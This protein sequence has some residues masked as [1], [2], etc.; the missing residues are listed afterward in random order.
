MDESLIP[1]E[2]ITIVESDATKAVYLH[3]L[4]KDERAVFIEEAI[5]SAAQDES[6]ISLYLSMGELVDGDNNYRIAAS[7]PKMPELLL[8][9]LI[10]IS[11][12]VCPIYPLIQFS[13]EKEVPQALH[14]K[15][16]PTAVSRASHAAPEDEM[17]FAIRFNTRVPA[18]IKQTQ[19]RALIPTMIPRNESV[20]ILGIYVPNVL[21]SNFF[22]KYVVPFAFDG[23][24]FVP[25]TSNALVDVYPKKN[26]LEIVDI[27]YAAVLRLYN[28]ANQQIVALTIAN[29]APPIIQK[30][31]IVSSEILVVDKRADIAAKNRAVKLF[32]DICD[33][34]GIYPLFA[35]DNQKELSISTATKVDLYIMGY[36]SVIYLLLFSKK[37]T[38]ENEIFVEEFLSHIAQYNAQRSL[39]SRL[40]QSA[41]IRDGQIS[42]VISI[43]RQTLG[44]AALQAATS[45][46]FYDAEEL[47]SR[48]PPK[49]RKLVEMEIARE[50]VY[51]Q[52]LIS[53]TC[54]HLRIISRIRA[55]KM[56]IPAREELLSRFKREYIKSK[57]GETAREIYTCRKCGLPL[58]CPHQIKAIELEML[59]RP[60][61][62]QIR[63]EMREF[64]VWMQDYKIYA[65]GICGEIIEDPRLLDDK[66]DDPNFGESDIRD[67]KLQE[68][69]WGELMGITR[70]FQLR[71]VLDPIRFYRSIARNVYPFIQDIEREIGKAKTSSSQEKRLKVQLFTIIYLFCY[72]SFLV[73][74]IPR[75]A[76]IIIP[77]DERGN[78]I[79][80]GNTRGID[81]HAIGVL[82]KFIKDR[83]LYA[84]NIVLREIPGASADWLQMRIIEVYKQIRQRGATGLIDT[85]T[86]IPKSEHLTLTIAI[87]E[88]PI[89]SY[90]Q[91]MTLDM[92]TLRMPSSESLEK[93]IGS[94]KDYLL[95]HRM[96]LES[97]SPLERAKLD[98]AHRI[99][100]RLRQL[101]AKEA[102]NARDRAAGEPQPIVSVF[103]TACKK[104][105]TLT[106]KDAQSL[107]EATLGNEA[108]I[109]QIYAKIA[110][111]SFELL[112]EEIR[113]ALYLIPH[114]EEVPVISKKDKTPTE[115][116][117]QRY[118]SFYSRL[119]AVYDISRAA[120]NIFD[121]RYAQ[122]TMVRS[123]II[124]PK[125]WRRSSRIIIP[126]PSFNFDEFG[127]PHK[128]G[129]SIL[130]DGSEKVGETYMRIVDKKC[131]ICGILRSKRESLNQEKVKSALD[132]QL[133][134][135]NFYSFFEIRCPRG[136]LH[137]SR[138]S[139][140][141]TCAKCGYASQ[142]AADIYSAQ[143]REYFEN[144]R[145]S[146]DVLI[147]L[148]LLPPQPEIPPNV[149]QPA[150]S[151]ELENWTFDYES[152]IRTGELFRVSQKFIASLGAKNGQ[153][154][155]DIESGKFVPPEPKNR[156]DR[157][158]FILRGYVS[159]ICADYQFLSNLHNVAKSPNWVI[160]ILEKLN[161]SK[162]KFESTVE[163]AI[164]PIA[165]VF[166]PG[167]IPLT[168]AFTYI[169][170]TRKPREV[171]DFLLQLICD[172]L[173]NIKSIKKMPEAQ[174]A[175]RGEIAANA[176]QNSSS[177]D[178]AVRA[179]IML[180]EHTMN[181]IID[182][183]RL[184]L[185]PG[186][187]S[188]DLVQKEAA[189]LLRGT[190]AVNAE[191]QT[192]DA[193][194]IPDALDT[195]DADEGERDFNPEMDDPLS[196][197]AFDVD[198]EFDAEDDATKIEDDER[199]LIH[200][201]D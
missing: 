178:L 55:G 185:K 44:P 183:E 78:P 89:F 73:V 167:T 10:L 103:H 59:T 199:T 192:R 14:R 168:P 127:R 128:W 24:I 153:T 136:T 145:V 159:R 135:R 156:Y 176:A 28:L 163:S 58:I 72:I 130:K 22:G 126:A 122:P 172:A 37:L 193:N 9:R 54:D 47:L 197:D 151:K 87:L 108:N 90:L 92:K 8:R 33:K 149:R 64:I 191:D 137:E 123:A 86:D 74:N 189:T 67:E 69:I 42:H 40:R 79:L 131:S 82:L 111:A 115:V 16:K 188:I 71:S 184:S 35:T 77:I 110:D 38:R 11:Q 187:F 148:P 62:M 119:S 85:A 152:I 198:D 171:A 57:S 157:R 93:V 53:N 121:R 43:I 150:P 180:A 39:R 182:A 132:T 68:I 61:P 5:E 101:S 76:E 3:S 134:I 186:Y 99:R 133:I 142:F 19:A 100:Q 120:D 75:M 106:E 117:S 181:T 164:P 177:R 36:L 170:E 17:S 26:F 23:H 116:I 147:K 144:N 175:G 1:S 141:G 20:F 165:A 160:S 6:L 32:L 45:S 88:D 27:I 140:G 114:Y 48:I 51:L 30:P 63:N 81:K 102:K 84:K 2:Q 169:D 83:V 21:V 190:S 49:G 113:D 46:I 91:K 201:E 95:H 158:I 174:H 7:K 60:N 155:A 112:C 139:L 196:L 166:P 96:A 34:L 31:A 179:V 118:S 29:F 66:S 138:Q 200:L 56:P 162:P 94:V 125:Y 97:L 12:S 50:K 105:P 4:T 80:R 173:N 18:I 98:P 25:T 195:S 107:G 143:S 70:Y 154:L 194:L 104:I 129:I 146:F 161:I 41:I 13:T 109:K 52:Q 65:C 124:A 15:Q